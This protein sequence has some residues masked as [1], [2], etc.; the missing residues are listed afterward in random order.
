MKSFARYSAQSK[1]YDA[2]IGENRGNGVGGRG[3]DPRE[4]L[5]MVQ[6]WELVPFDYFRIGFL[7]ATRLHGRTRGK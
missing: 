3:I 2:A 5:E 4:S 6:G 1:F 7:A